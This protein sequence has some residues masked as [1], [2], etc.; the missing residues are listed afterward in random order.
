MQAHSGWSTTTFPNTSQ[1]LPSTTCSLAGIMSPCPVGA[2]TFRLSV[3]VRYSQHPSAGEFVELGHGQGVQMTLE[4]NTSLYVTVHQLD[5]RLRTTGM[6]EDYR[7]IG[8]EVFEVRKFLAFCCWH[9]LILLQVTGSSTVAGFALV[10]SLCSVFRR[11]LCTC[12]ALFA[13]LSPFKLFAHVLLALSCCEPHKTGRSL[14]CAEA[15][16]M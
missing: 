9:T 12:T 14:S 10:G 16:T 8:F 7:D 13:V 1:K 3:I 4:E 6:Q 5:L 2:S 15:D 11:T